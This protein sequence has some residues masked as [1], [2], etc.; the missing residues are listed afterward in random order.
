MTGNTFSGM[1]NK[2]CFSETLDLKVLL[3]V[4]FGQVRHLL[5]LRGGH[6]I[7]AFSQND[8][9]LEPPSPLF[10]LVRFW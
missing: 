9:N 6:S 2:L 7:I 3:I 8:Q 10:A 5:L 4:S 1:A